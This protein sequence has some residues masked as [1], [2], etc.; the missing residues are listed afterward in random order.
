MHSI[1]NGDEDGLDCEQER[2]GES[3]GGGH[4]NHPGSGDSSGEVQMSSVV[5]KELTGLGDGPAGQ[6]SE[7]EVPG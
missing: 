7:E 3:S 1:G 6:M 4:G 5:E 2:R